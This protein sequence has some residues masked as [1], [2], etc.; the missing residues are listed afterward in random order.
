MAH[1]HT[2][3]QGGPVDTSEPLPSEL[4]GAPVT[5]ASVTVKI[6][7]PVPF[8]VFPYVSSVYYT[9]ARADAGQGAVEAQHDFVVRGRKLI[10]AFFSIKLPEHIPLTCQ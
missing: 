4:A 5:A 6:K 7:N 10:S 9:Y 2:H 1:T 8:V 3:T